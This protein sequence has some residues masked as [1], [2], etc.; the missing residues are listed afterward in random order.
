MQCQWVINDWETIIPNLQAGDYDAIMAGMSITDEREE[1][2]D[3][4]Q[5]Y[6][7]PELSVFAALTG[8]GEEATRKRVAVQTATVQA[9]YLEGKVASL[10]EYPLAEDTI[11]AVLGG[12]ADST[13]ASISYLQDIVSGSDGALSFVGPEVPLDKGTGMGL[14]EGETELREKLDGAIEEMKQDGSL[15]NLIRKWF[16]ENARTF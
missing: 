13:L 1:L 2:I 3:F 6:F 5:P 16:G 7:P 14:R 8:A 9:D 10:Q 15:D 11:A 4:T 12:Q